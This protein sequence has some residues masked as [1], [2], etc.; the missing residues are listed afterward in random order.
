MNSRLKQS[1]RNYFRSNLDSAKNDP[2]KTWKLI[3]QL[4]SG[5]N[6]KCSNINKVELN[7]V[8]ISNTCEIGEAFNTHFTEIGDNLTKKSL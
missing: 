6:D 5:S 3:N 2:K 8:E 7:D 1:K 4:T